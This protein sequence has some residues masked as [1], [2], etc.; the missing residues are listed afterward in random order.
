MFQKSSSRNAPSRCDASDARL[1]VAL[2]LHKTPCRTVSLR[3]DVSSARHSLPPPQRN[4]PQHL[5]LY[6][7][8]GRAATGSL[9]GAVSQ[10]LHMKHKMLK[11]PETLVANPPQ[12]VTWLYT[13]CP[14][15]CRW[16]T[17]RQGQHGD[18]KRCIERPQRREQESIREWGTG[19][20]FA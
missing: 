18:S 16:G 6:S 15:S 20:V 5:T 17:F 13:G 8:L 12:H 4:M 11:V 1:P 2:N 19:P 7:M 9:L 14:R 3:T 10:R